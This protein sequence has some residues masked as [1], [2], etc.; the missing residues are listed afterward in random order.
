MCCFVFS[1]GKHVDILDHDN[2]YTT[3]AAHRDYAEKILSVLLRIW[4]KVLFYLNVSP[5]GGHCPKTQQ[6]VTVHTEW[7]A[8]SCQ[9]LCSTNCCKEL[10]RVVCGCQVLHY[11]TQ[12]STVSIQVALIIKPAHTTGAVFWTFTVSEV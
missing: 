2:D 10:Q 1:S 12:I 11:I 9:C 5:D 8:P 7:H 6:N 3:D 4:G